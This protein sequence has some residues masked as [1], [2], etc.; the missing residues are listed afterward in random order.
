M[1]LS[2]SVDEFFDVDSINLS[3]ELNIN[4]TEQTE[5]D[6]TEEGYEKQKEDEYLIEEDKEASKESDSFHEERKSNLTQAETLLKDDL[7]NSD[8]SN[9]FDDFDDFVTAS[10]VSGELSTRTKD[11][12]EALKSQNSNKLYELLLPETRENA[13]SST[14][15]TPWNELIKPAFDEFYESLRV[16]GR[17]N[18]TNYRSAKVPPKKLES[19]APKIANILRKAT[20]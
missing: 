4:N 18:K 14:T 10:P 6:L 19:I 17:L 13:S 7:D 20:E 3:N 1:E 12:L 5:K 2:K 15:P 8:D 16:S 11:L 9:G